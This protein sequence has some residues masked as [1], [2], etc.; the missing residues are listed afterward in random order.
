MK[1]LLFVALVLATSAYGQEKEIL[2]K[3]LTENFQV[4]LLAA[5][6][7]ETRGQYLIAKFLETSP[8]SGRGREFVVAFPAHSFTPH[9]QTIIAVIKS[10][11][12]WDSS[13]DPYEFHEATGEVIFSI[14]KDIDGRPL[15]FKRWFL[16]SI[17]TKA[18]GKP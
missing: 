4:K 7:S 12:A 17:R 6:I 9:E 2:A 14:P 5:K 15:E 3:D 18:D 1:Y 10:C 16:I 8:K 13:K 11:V